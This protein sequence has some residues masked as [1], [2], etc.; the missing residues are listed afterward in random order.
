MPATLPSLIYIFSKTTFSHQVAASY[1][2]ADCP[3]GSVVKLLSPADP[4]QQVSPRARVR[5]RGSSVGAGISVDKLN[6]ALHTSLKRVRSGRGS[7]AEFGVDSLFCY[8][9]LRAWMDPLHAFCVFLLLPCVLP[10]DR[11]ICE[12]NCRAGR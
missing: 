5:T 10:L 8:F 12:R 2:G 9:I 3:G 1:S 4:P 11:V 7:W 6:Q